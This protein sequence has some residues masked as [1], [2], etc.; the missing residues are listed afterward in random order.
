[1][2]EARFRALLRELIDE[3]PF[4]IRAVLKILHIEF[5]TD[6]PTLAVT[7]EERPRLLV[8][9]EFVKKHCCTDA[10][11]K[12]VVCH[13]FLHVLL[14]H[15]EQKG[16]FTP[17]RHL[18]FDAVI[19]AIIHREFGADYSGMMSAYYAK[20]VGLAKLL[21]PMTFAERQWYSQHSGSPGRV[22]QWAHAWHGLYEGKLVA[23]DIE[24]L[25]D[26]LAKES[27]K[28]TSIGVAKRLM[29]AGTGPFT[30]N[31]QISTG[32]EHLLGDHAEL[33]K[34]LPDTLS[35]ALNRALKEMNGS[36]IWR[37]PQK[38]GA[39]INPY[40]AILNAKDEPMLKWQRKT[41]AI[42][43]KHLSPDLRSKARREEP[44]SYCIPVLSP[45]DRRAFVR[46]LW[47][48]FLPDTTWNT[49]VLA[50]VGTAQVYL[51]LS[52]SMEAELPLIITLLGRLSRYIRR[53]FWA[54]ST[55]VAP[56]TIEHG[57]LKANTSG[58]TS[59]ACV[60]EHVA[61]TRPDSA[62]VVTDGYIESV[63]PALVK[64]A[65]RTRLHVLLTRDGSA[66][67]VER[68]GLPY[69]QLDKVPE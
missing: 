11:V 59:M 10:H 52:G 42:L 35:D 15:T 40:D 56:A 55:V 44:S 17:S 23:D 43:K 20:A 49:H 31:G 60:L 32:A 28:D 18:A 14:R 68:I 25:A 48:P 46:S 21:R 27:E 34:A 13:E 5:T 67:E 64:R 69:T 62:V 12:A 51:D 9:L 22:P 58:G 7:C 63:D 38:H 54:F 3:N 29:G 37:S 8:N 45:Q 65:S 19:N 6:V 61:R 16:S 47:D 26:D 4:A 53:P 2:N 30:L 33:D 39:G 1:M 50:P 24:S 66:A 41:L 57:Q 36:G